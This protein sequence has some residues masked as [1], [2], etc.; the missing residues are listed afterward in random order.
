MLLPYTKESTMMSFHKFSHISCKV[1]E[2]VSEEL[3]KTVA[4]LVNE[5]QKSTGLV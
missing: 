4:K 1:V 3:P 5:V 2:V